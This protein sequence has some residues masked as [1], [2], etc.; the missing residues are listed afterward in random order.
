MAAIA[1]V[2][3][4]VFRAEEA[5]RMPAD[6]SLAVMLHDIRQPLSS[7]Q[8]VAYYLEMTIPAHQVEAR[9]MLLKLQE[10][11][12]D[13]GGLLDRAERRALERR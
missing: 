7:I 10:M 11:V 8:A 5:T 3:D 2:H 4:S 9:A 13:A 1:L 12:Q 6:P